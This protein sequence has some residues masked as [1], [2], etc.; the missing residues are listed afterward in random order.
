MRLGTTLGDEASPIAVQMLKHAHVSRPLTWANKLSRLIRQTSQQYTS[1]LA[2]EAFLLKILIHFRK[3]EQT[4]WNHTRQSSSRC[5]ASRT[6]SASSLPFP[7]LSLPVATQRR[8][9]FWSPGTSLLSS[10]T[11]SLGHSS[12]TRPRSA[13]TSLSSAMVSGMALWILITSSVGTITSL[14]SMKVRLNTFTGA[15]CDQIGWDQGDS[16]DWETIKKNIKFFNTGT[17]LS[18]LLYAFDPSRLRKSTKSRSPSL[19]PS[20]HDYGKYIL[21]SLQ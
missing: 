5:S 16:Y 17:F 6:S 2:L 10:A 19:T 12:T 14:A 13:R 21:A 9:G 4:S 3:V 18:Q 15:F 20:M 11:N 7:R 8:N 1:D